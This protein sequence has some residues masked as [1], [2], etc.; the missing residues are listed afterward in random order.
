MRPISTLMCKVL[1]FNLIFMFLT[2]ILHVLIYP[3]ISPFLFFFLSYSIS[4]SYI[5]ITVA[6]KLPNISRKWV[7]NN[8]QGHWNKLLMWGLNQIF[9][10]EALAVFKGM[11]RHF[12]LV[13]QVATW[14]HLS[15]HHLKLQFCNI[16]NDI[17]N[18]SPLWIEYLQNVTLREKCPDTDQ[19]KLRIRTIFT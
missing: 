3:L 4:F 11:L 9:L 5:L 6:F 13:L 2:V 17:S 18:V 8:I 19:K 16:V 1:M 14:T 12:T 10:N 7:D 15:V